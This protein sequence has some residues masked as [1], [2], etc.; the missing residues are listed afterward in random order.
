MRIVIFCARQ[1]RRRDNSNNEQTKFVD[2][3]N[4]DGAGATGV[5]T[6]QPKKRIVL[7]RRHERFVCKR[8][9]AGLYSYNI[10]NYST[11]PVYSYLRLS[12][13]GKIII[14]RANIT[15]ERKLPV[16]P[17]PPNSHFARGNPVKYID[18]EK[19][20]ADCVLL[21]AA[22][23]LAKQIVLLVNIKLYLYIIFSPSAWSFLRGFP[24]V[25]DSTNLSVNRYFTTA[26]Y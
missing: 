19:I 20:P 16:L 9:T 11:T 25:F 26:I 13:L 18:D 17:D 21:H 6:F 10:L 15:N 22:V 1:Q 7:K 8:I 5:S 2:R 23:A 3:Y 14:L 12:S 24:T 4:T